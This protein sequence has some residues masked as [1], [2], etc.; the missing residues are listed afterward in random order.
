MSPFDLKTILGERYNDEFFS[1]GNKYYEMLQTEGILIFNS[2]INN[3]GLA[4]LQKE[5]SDLKYLS[6]NLL[7]P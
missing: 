1:N 4:I 7:S 6:Y 3:N 2:F 5:A